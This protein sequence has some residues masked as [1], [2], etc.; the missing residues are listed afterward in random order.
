MTQCEQNGSLCYEHGSE[1]TG[2][3]C[4]ADDPDACEPLNK[5]Q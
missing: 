5:T 4:D 2:E 3:T 1:C